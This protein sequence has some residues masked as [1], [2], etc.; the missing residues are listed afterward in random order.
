MSTSAADALIAFY[1]GLGPADIE[2]FP[3]FY[4]D[5]AFFKDPFNEVRGVVA[6]QRIFRHLFSQLAE[7]RFVVLE[8]VAAENGTLLLWEMHFRR[9]DGSGRG[10][11]QLIRGASH[12]RFDAAGKVVWHRDY[13][14][15]AEELYEKLP[16]IGWLMR[17]LKRRLAA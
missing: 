5:D 3:A 4:A 13:W 8:R 2:R 16:G 1:E 10:Q 7:P 14:D 12:L 15:A 6:I 11:A 9:P 17:L